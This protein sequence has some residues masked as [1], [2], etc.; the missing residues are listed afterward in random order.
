MTGAAIGDPFNAGGAIL[1]G[2]LKRRQISFSH[3]CEL[4]RGQIAAAADGDLHAFD[5]EQRY[6]REKN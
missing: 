4:H 1:A 2:T 5:G 3:L 6:F